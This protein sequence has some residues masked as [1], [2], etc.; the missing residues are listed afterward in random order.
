MDENFESRDTAEWL[1]E[2]Q[3]KWNALTPEEQEE[4]RAVN[5]SERKRQ[6][7][8]IEAAGGIHA[9]MHQQEELAM[10]KMMGVD[11]ALRDIP[12]LPYDDYCKFLNI[13]G[14]DN[15]LIISGSVMQRSGQEMARASVLISPEGLEN[16]RKSLEEEYYHR[17]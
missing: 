8:E 16:A 10:Q 4:I 13:L 3:R 6:D 2:H 12:W 7:Q 5:L 1:A 17:T 14:E 15:V 9:W 11:W